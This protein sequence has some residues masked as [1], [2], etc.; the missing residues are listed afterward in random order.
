M[1]PVFTWVLRAGLALLMSVAA[2]HKAQDLR[3]F[4]D[5]LRDYRVLPVAAV[6]IV[7]PLIV[8]TEAGIAI[9][10]LVPGLAPFATAP[11]AAAL[12]GGLLLV[13][14]AAIATN[15]ARGRRHIDCGCLGPRAR[16]PISG[17][18]LAR[19]GVLV[20]ASLLAAVPVNG[21]ALLWVDAISIGGGL[22]VV[23]LLFHSTN[24]LTVQ[25]PSWSHLR[26]PS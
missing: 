19:N 4:T 17:W 15:L 25:A 8:L 14:S 13:Y 3:A 7:A 22:A 23:A 16:Q 26:R 24:I 5:T 9:G 11:F 20:A 12:C 10:L 1:D 18:L 2:V 6:G 21:R